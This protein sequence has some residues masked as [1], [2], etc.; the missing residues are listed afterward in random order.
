MITDG[1]KDSFGFTP[2][3]NNRDKLFIFSITEK[4]PAHKV[5]L[6]I[7]SNITA[8]NGKNTK[9]FT[10][11]NLCLLMEKLSSKKT[12]FDIRKIGHISGR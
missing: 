7:G 11:E 4:I 12:S 8:V 9:G 1:F 10:K 3:W 6:K 2:M 5:E